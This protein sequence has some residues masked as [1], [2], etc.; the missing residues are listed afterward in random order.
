[1]TDAGEPGEADGHTCDPVPHR[2][3]V[4]TVRIDPIDHRELLDTLSDFLAC[5][6]S[7][8]VHFIP[9]HPTVLA[10]R[11]R[12]YREVLN[13]GRLNLPDGAS[14]ALVCRLHGSRTGRLTGSDAMRIVTGWG[15]GRGLRHYLFGGTPETL[16]ALR[17]KLESARPGIAIAG[18]ESPPFRDLG[19]EEL[20]A[21]VGRM[22]AVDAQA[23]WVG[24]GTPKQ[25]LIADRLQ[26]MRAAPVILCV[27]AA[28][29]FVSGSVARAPRWVSG[30]GLEWAYRLKTDP[31]RLWRRY[32]LGNP[33]FVAGVLFD[34]LTRPADRPRSSSTPPCGS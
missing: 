16:L 25:D 5:G 30:L 33:R 13:R 3:V 6:Q 24:L 23:V 8:V 12:S 29:D 14:V 11:D 7:H 21:V 18:A 32:V 15:L 19:D 10:R 27:G 20:R 34:E 28:F 31:R 4:N 9:A 17:T 26:R 22:R 2:P 1:M